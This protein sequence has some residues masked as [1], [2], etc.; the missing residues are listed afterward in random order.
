M[1]KSKYLKKTTQPP[2]SQNPHQPKTNQ[3]K[4]TE[5]KPK[6]KLKNHISIWPSMSFVF[7]FWFFFLI[8]LNRY[9][10][11]SLKIILI[12]YLNVVT[13]MSHVTF[14]SA[15]FLIYKTIVRNL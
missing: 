15:A 3:K 8:F 2:S 1:I 9:S 14:V 10:R 5:K 13:D 12:N 7:W 11:K 4:P 6:P